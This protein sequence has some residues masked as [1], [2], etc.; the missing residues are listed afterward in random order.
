MCCLKPALM[1]LRLSGLGLRAYCYAD[2]TFHRFWGHVPCKSDVMQLLLNC[3][4]NPSCKWTHLFARLHRLSIF[5]DWW[6]V[7]IRGFH[8]ASSFCVHVQVPVSIKSLCYLLCT[9]VRVWD[10]AS[11]LCSSTIEVHIEKVLCVAIS[12]SGKTIVSGCGDKT[13]R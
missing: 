13:V 1:Q 12:P 7:R 6:F 4:D 3:C 2:C 8:S 11:G 5:S 9:A 10:L